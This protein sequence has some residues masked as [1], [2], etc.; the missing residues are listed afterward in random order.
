LDV[1]DLLIIAELDSDC[2]QSFS[3]IAVKLG[4]T[5]R[6]VQ[7]R[8]ARLVESGF[9]GSFEILFDHSALGLGQATCNLRLRSNVAVS[10]IKTKL[11]A[12]PAV[13]EV[14][15]FVGGVLVTYV[16]YENQVQLEDILHRMGSIDGVADID[17]EIG[18][19]SDAP[20]R[21]GP[22]DWRL[23]RSLNHQARRELVEIAEET[24]RSPRTIQRRLRF[25]ERTGV[26]RFGLQVDISKA[27]D[28]F[29]YLVI[30]RLLPGS[31]KA[32]VHNTARQLVPRIWRSIRS[33][34]PFLLT[35]AST[36]GRLSDLERDVELLRTIPSVQAVSVLF[37]TSD[38][39]SNDW[40]DSFI[41]DASARLV[42]R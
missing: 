3:A 2:R 33:V 26:V 1:S 27:T 38:S 8:V 30:V 40:L 12:L 28:L 37:N 4:M 25:L 29:P 9:I 19:R 34:N 20:V 16:S 11:L 21:L 39:V 36:A 14:L 31:N 15:T 35:L 5:R 23:L 17:Y 32:R 18:P 42:A 13:T 6:T 41:N 7:R 22:S 24:G 10:S